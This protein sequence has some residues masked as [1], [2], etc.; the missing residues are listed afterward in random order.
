MHTCSQKVGEWI[1]DSMAARRFYI[2]THPDMAGVIMSRA[3]AMRVDYAACMDD[4][5]FAREEQ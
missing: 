2:F 4:P 5:R 3:R 1:A